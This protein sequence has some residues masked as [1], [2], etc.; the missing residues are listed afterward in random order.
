MALA[1]SDLEPITRT[2]RQRAS[3]GVKGGGTGTPEVNWR[4]LPITGS[5]ALR[6]ARARDP[7]GWG[8]APKACWIE[9]VHVS[10]AARGLP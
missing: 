6:L 10:G 3:K 7:L 1:R 9:L 2:V 4:V 8:V 5:L